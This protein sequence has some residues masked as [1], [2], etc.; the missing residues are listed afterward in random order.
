MGKF[1]L[2]KLKHGFVEAQSTKPA[3]K[4]DCYH[5][6]KGDA[7]SCITSGSACGGFYGLDEHSNIVC[8]YAYKEKECQ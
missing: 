6:D 5:W 1:D 7:P 3:Y 2:N 8:G 4:K